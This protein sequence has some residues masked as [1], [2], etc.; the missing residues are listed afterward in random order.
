ML[1]WRTLA[2][3]TPEYYNCQF[4]DRLRSWLQLAVLFILKMTAITDAAAYEGISGNNRKVETVTRRLDVVV[5]TSYRISRT[6]HDC[7][8]DVQLTG[9]H[10]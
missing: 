4:S 6:S 3:H 10:Q 8:V 2:I 9:F 1:W 5:S 7:S